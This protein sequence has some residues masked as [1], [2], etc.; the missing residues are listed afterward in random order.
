MSE[1]FLV[2][3]SLN[4]VLELFNMKVFA[5]HNPNPELRA[6]SSAGGVFS[7]LAETVLKHGGVVYGAAFDDNWNIVYRRVDS[8]DQIDCLRRS[9]YAYGK[10]G[11]SI[12]EAL[13]DLQEGKKV[14]F[15]GVPCQVAAMRKLA[16]ES[17]NLLLV[18]VVCHGAPKHEYWEI[19]LSE[20]CQH[21]K[22]EVSEIESI[23][24]RDKRTGWKNYSFTIK[25]KDGK[26]F[27]Q[28]HDDNLYMRAFIMDLS[29]REPCFECNFKYPSGTQADI[30]LGDFWGISQIAP[31]IDNNLGTTLI[32]ARTIKGES[33]VKKLQNLRNILFDEAVKYN[34][35]IVLPPLKPASFNAFIKFVK[36]NTFM[37]SLNRFAARPILQTIRIKIAR[38]KYRLL[39]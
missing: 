9:K 36:E 11:N 22:K 29:L 17:Q 23:N 26:E 21:L 10:I 6:Q 25:F 16:G 5:S 32:I 30:T 2:F 20:L 15:S 3:H 35:A 13:S 24:F 31:E 33:A 39:K 14:L 37:S 12:K 19:Y 4:W 27:S 7:V 18:E 8:F 1:N 38:F 34:K 28:P